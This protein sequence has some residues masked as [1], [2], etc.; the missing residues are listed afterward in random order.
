MELQGCVVILFNF[1]RN[2]QPFPQWLRHATHPLVTWESF[3]FSSSLLAF[4]F[5]SKHLTAL[6]CFF[7]GQI[8]GESSGGATSI[9]RSGSVM[10]TT[11]VIGD[12]WGRLPLCWYLVFGFAVLT[13]HLTSPASCPVAL[14]LARLT[15]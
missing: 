15:I 11:T 8:L 6:C 9:S 13:H 1:M 12:G 3:S 10:V 4:I 5:F 7:E 2:C 14:S